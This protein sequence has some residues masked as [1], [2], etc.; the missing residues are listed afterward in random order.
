MSNG[1]Q[2]VAG[3][4]RVCP[5][6]K[7]AILES[8]S[9]CPACRHHLRFAPGATP[10]SVPSFSPLQVEG[11]ITNPADGEPWEYS[12][13]L[14]IQNDKGEVIARQVVGVGALNPSERRK[15]SLA[16]EVFTPGGR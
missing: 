10:R 4:T 15:F 5:H 13:V 16:V 11:T 6:C 2:L 3:A 7:A 1:R 12:M 9:V 8:A 14:S